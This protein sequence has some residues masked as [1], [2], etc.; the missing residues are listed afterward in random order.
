MD[1][2]LGERERLK[3]QII[4]RAQLPFAEQRAGFEDSLIRFVE[5]AW[6]S[7]D[8]APYQPSWAIDALCEHL[9]AVADGQIRKLLVNLSPRCGKTLVTSVCFPAWVWAQ[10]DISYLKGPQVRFLCGSY[11]DDLSLQN[12]TRHRRLLLSPWYQRYWGRRFQLTQDQSAKAK[13]DTTAGGSRISTSARGLLLGVGGDCLVV[14][15]PHNL[16]RAK[17]KDCRR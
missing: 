16:P 15:D 17:Q 12:S 9:Q 6:S 10:R 8:P 14:D 13:F 4:A 5:G 1:A 3:L 7:L 2:P 11:N